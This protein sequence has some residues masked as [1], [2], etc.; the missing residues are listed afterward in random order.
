MSEAEVADCVECHD[1][2]R[3]IYCV[4]DAVL[5]CSRCDELYHAQCVGLGRVP[6]AY[7]RRD[8]LCPGC[9]RPDESNVREDEA[10][11]ESLP[12]E[13]IVDIVRLAATGL[14]TD[15]AHHKQEYLEEILVKILGATEFERLRN[16]YA[17]D[18]YD[19][20]AEI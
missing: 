4:D 13:S 12:S 19:W 18:G 6:R 9:I 3:D 16:N 7:V 11:P 17:I 20:E 2:Q 1:C 8:Y 15:G 14:S 10:I 5:K